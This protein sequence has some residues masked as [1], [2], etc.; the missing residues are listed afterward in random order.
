M[1]SDIINAQ[2]RCIAHEIRNHLSIC[3]LYTE[4]IKKNIDNAG[5]KNK[6][7]ENALNCIKKSLKIMNNSLLDLKSLN[8]LKQDYYDLK[9]VLSQGIEMSEVYVRDKNIKF[10]SDIDVTGKVFI[11]ENKFLACIVNIIKNAVEA[12]SDEGTITVNTRK[13]GDNICILI[14]NNGSAISIQK[15]KEIFNEGFTTKK[16]GSG[17][18]LHI[19]KNNL[20][21]QNASIDLL[22]SDEKETVFQISLPIF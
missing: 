6:S 15:Q 2:S 9:S 21:L 1:E 11:D 14:S 19:C 16:T 10:L 18:G 5:F 20:Q 4:I 13:K 12:I 17:L 7:V 3:D 22:K 8:N